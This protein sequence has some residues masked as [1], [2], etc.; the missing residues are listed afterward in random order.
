MSVL[1]F[2]KW[3]HPYIALIS[4]RN[5]TENSACPRQEVALS[6]YLL[7]GGIKLN[8]LILQSHK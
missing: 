2:S 4:L 7:G 5:F 3:I 6:Y 1:M 8:S